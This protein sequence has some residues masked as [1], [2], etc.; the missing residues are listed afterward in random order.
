[1]GVIDLRTIYLNFI[2]T[3]FISLIFIVLLW[4]QN[5][6]R[7][8][9]LHLLVF[10]FL[11]QLI[12][13]TL[14]FLRGIIPDFISIVAANFGG[15]VAAWLGLVGF[16]KFVGRK[17]NPWLNGLVVLAFSLVQL[18][19]TVFDPELSYRNLN[20]AVGY[21]FFGA[22]SAWLLLYL[23]PRKLRSF[24][25][26]TGILFVCFSLVNLVRIVFILVSATGHEQNYFHTGGVES[27][28]A[29][30][31]QITLLLLCFFVVL[32]INK[33]LVSDI[34]QEE[35]KLSIAY[36]AVP[37]AIIITR[38][39]DGCILD[40]ND[41]FQQI[42]K[43]LRSDVIG[44]TSREL[45]LWSHDD[46][47]DFLVTELQKNNMVRDLEFYF[48]IK[49]GEMLV[50]NLSCINITVDNQDCMLSV[51]NDI[52]EQKRAERE[53]KKSRDILKKLVVNLQTEHEIEKI[54]LA[55]QID[56][57]LN[58]SLAALRI[59]IGTLKRG[60]RSDGN[61][62]SD[63]LMDLVDNTYSQAGTTIERSLSLM[64]NMRN[65]VLHLLGFVE[66]LTYS[67]E[68]IEKKSAVSC[69]FYC[70]L[71]K[72]EL[73][74]NKSTVLFNIFQEVVNHILQTN[75]ARKLEIIL[76]RKDDLLLLTISEDGNSFE[77]YFGSDN[78]NS[79]LHVMKE[80]AA[81]FNG[82]LDVKREEFSTVISIEMKE[83]TNVVEWAG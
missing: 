46:E 73:D 77:D 22:Q 19:F 67:V 31:Y 50:G 76:D 9:G 75:R 38:K 24:T 79:S 66:A 25:V 12:C 72:T 63:K 4:Y 62:V 20:I 8:N 60:L 65:E 49:T 1:M 47:R 51:I 7:Y 29:V 43:Y 6:R 53:I 48:R 54:N 78:D 81:L 55:S 10:D 17:S 26:N 40:V 34:T 45:K 57:S 82:I 3:D 32:M 37:Y 27:V 68:E 30:L 35:Q 59:N 56:N 14:I 33:R 16:E 44:R 41:G 74:Q 28:V 70:G 21:L 52:T 80:K 61:V 71:N 64:N 2:L 11:L 39:E 15:I 69:R 5:R 18:Y 83:K 13:I 36:H 23:T 58:Q 42:S